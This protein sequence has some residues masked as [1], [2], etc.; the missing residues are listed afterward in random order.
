MSVTG[1]SAARSRLNV[2]TC[3]R[4]PWLC[5]REGVVGDPG[6]ALVLQALGEQRGG[7]ELAAVVVVLLAAQRLSVRGGG[8]GVVGHRRQ[9][10][11][12]V[13]RRV[14]GSVGERLTRSEKSCRS[15]KRS[16]TGRWLVPVM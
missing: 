14:G 3:R 16:Q 10:G 8:G 15:V 6:E 12:L 1:L 2:P 13:H 5:E 9:L 11:V 7:D 4:P